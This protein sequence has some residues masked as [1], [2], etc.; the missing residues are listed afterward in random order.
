M[1][2]HFVTLPVSPD[3]VKVP[4]LLPV[5]TEVLVET[6]PPTVAVAQ[7]KQL[8]AGLQKEGAEPNFAL[9]LF[10]FEYDQLNPSR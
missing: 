8:P 4:E 10:V 3:N 1:Y 5:Q 6:E 9:P 7:G 2:C